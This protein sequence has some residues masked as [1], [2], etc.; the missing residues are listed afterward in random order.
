MC[1]ILKISGTQ[2]CQVRGFPVE[3][4]Y[5]NTVAAG[6]FSCPQV[7]A[8]PILWYLA[9]G[10]PILSV[11]T[12]PKN[13]LYPQK[14]PLEHDL[15]RGNTTGL[16]LN[17]N[18]VVLLWKPGNPGGTSYPTVPYIYCREW[19]CLIECKLLPSEIQI[20]QQ[21]VSLS[22]CGRLEG[23]FVFV[24]VCVCVFVCVCVVQAGVQLNYSMAL[25]G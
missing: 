18:W 3:L 13:V 14:A 22:S 23:A 24:C 1:L 16:L 12:P 11:E 25:G 21:W 5:F 2:W 6:C 20:S 7:E 9:P 19:P 10:K 17:S 15:Y 8:T 4:G